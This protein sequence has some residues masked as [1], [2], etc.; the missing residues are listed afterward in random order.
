MGEGNINE[1][2]EIRDVLAKYDEWISPSIR[3]LGEYHPVLEENNTFAWRIADALYE[4]MNHEGLRY[5]TYGDGKC[6]VAVFFSLHQP[7]ETFP[8]IK[9]MV[10]PDTDEDGVGPFDVRGLAIPIKVRE[11]DYIHWKVDVIKCIASRGTEI[12]K[13]LK[14][15]ADIR[16]KVYKTETVFSITSCRWNVEMS[17]KDRIH[18]GDMRVIFS[19][20]EAPKEEEPMSM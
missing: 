3:L 5:S 17:P 13:I 11:G 19:C 16:K 6:H 1:T 10:G 18:Y 4:H 20:A 14:D 9:D 12:M 2:G 7:D 15:Y 8:L